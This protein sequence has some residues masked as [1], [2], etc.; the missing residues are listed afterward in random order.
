[1]RKIGQ[2]VGELDK[3]RVV[4]AALQETKWF[5]SKDV[6]SSCFDIQ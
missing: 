3:Y 2:V 6:Q 5:K 4:V 1:M